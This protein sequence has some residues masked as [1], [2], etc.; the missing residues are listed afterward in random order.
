MG[1]IAGFYR[2]ALGKKAVMAVTGFLLFGFVL[3]HMAGN[4]KL[5]LPP[6]AEGPHAGEHPINV[7]AVF[8]REVGSP[9]LPPGALLWV[10]RLAL[11]AA[12]A[13]HL[14]CAWA[15][16]RMSWAAR[17]VA[18]AKRGD[19]QLSYASRT[20]RWGGVIVGL[21][22]LFHLA[23]LTFG[24]MHPQFE[25]LKAHE[26]IVAGFAVWWVSAFYI[27]ANLALGFHLRHGLVAMF[28]SVG[29]ANPSFN[30]F[31]ERFAMLF[32]AVV[33]AGN[34]SFPLAVLSGF[35]R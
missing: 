2:S 32:A 10:A 35:V 7:Y 11:L 18:Y 26:N 13:L 21:F 9:M 29:W 33:T 23:H 19:V 34:V 27:V 6:Y 25:H 3:I 24:W 8:L 16:T 1:S 15:L 14:H 12:V 22:V 31:R 17:P 20:V 5:Y 28:Q 4:L 30:R